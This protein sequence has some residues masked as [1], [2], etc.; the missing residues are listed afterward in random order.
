VIE[1]D[2]ESLAYG[3]DAIGRLEDG[4]TA[5]V[6]GACPGDRVRVEI[7]EDRDRF[8]KAHVTEVVSPS[9]ERVAPPCPYF[10][11]CGGCSWQHV[12]YGAQ[13]ESK[14]QSVADALERIGRIPGARELVSPTVASKREYGYRNKVELVLDPSSA[15]PTLGFHR[16]GSDKVVPVD[17]CLLLPKKHQKAPRALGGSLRYLAGES[18][19]GL[20]R[21][22]Y[23]VAVRT[24]DVEVALWAAP[25]AFPRNAVARTLKQAVPATSIVRVLTKGPSKERSVSGVE[26]LLGRGNWRE[27]LGAFDYM[28]S[29]PSFF[30]VNT[31]AAESLVELV[32][33]ALQ[34]DGSDRALDLYAGAGTFTLPLAEHAGEVVAVESAGS[35]V[36][37]LRRNLESNQLWADVVGGDAA[38]EIAAL[39]HFDIVVVDPPRSGLAPQVVAALAASR[40]RDI[41]YVSCDPAT[42]ARDAR[43]LVDAGYELVSATPVDLFPQSYHIETVAHFRPRPS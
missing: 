3:G 34:P 10:G 27:R 31:R 28:V 25:G 41:A 16:A 13:C 5:F 4:R 40:P 38:R 7:D 39:G 2:I 15:R 37:D 6:R 11:E 14:R 42:L 33:S 23:R 12:A 30:Q 43:S 22:G 26:S 8:V 20:V 35:A 1:L 18:D 32:M 29:A 9:P 17:S 24:S 36:R 19:L 21:V